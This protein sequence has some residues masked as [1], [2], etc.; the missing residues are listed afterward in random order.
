M[1]NVFFVL[2]QRCTLR[3]SVIMLTY[4]SLG[5]YNADASEVACTLTAP[6]VVSVLPG[7]RWWGGF[8]AQG[9]KMPYKNN[10]GFVFD[11][12]RDNF[13][14]QTAP[15]LVSSKG[16]YLWS[17]DPFAYSFTDQG[18]EIDG[19]VDLQ[20]VKAGGNLRDAYLSASEA[21]F[22]FTGETPDSLFFI[23]PQYNTWIELAYNQNQRDVMNYAAAA[24]AHGFPPGIFM[25][26]DNWQRYYGNFDFKSE[27]FPAP[28]EMCDSLHDLGFKVMTWICPFVSPDSPE[29]RTMWS[30]SYLLKNTSK[31]LPAIIPWWNGLSAAVDLTNP[32]AR[33][34]FKSKLE[35]SRQKYGIDGFK[36]DAGDIQYMLPSACS[37]AD[38]AATAHDYAYLWALTGS[39]FRFNELRSAWKNGGQP[40]VQRLGDKDYSWAALHQLVGDMISAGLLG[41]AYTCPDMIGGGM[42]GTFYTAEAKSKPFDQELMVRSCQ[43]HS[44]MPMMQFSVAPWRVLSAENSEICARYARLHA[45][46][47]P[48]IMK[49]ADHASKTGEPIVRHLEYEFPGQGFEDCTTQYMLGP[50]YMIAP[51]LER[52]DR[53]KV[54][55]PLG[56]WIDDRGTEYEGGQT[57]EIDVPLDRLPVF[58]RHSTL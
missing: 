3:L 41:Y 26:D 56:R 46:M 54:D 43:I 49:W 50:E 15:L 27:R 52:G 45:E 57:I 21:H 24:L 11:L 22:P 53:R 33:D 47:S 58:R 13:N 14:N 6:T 32:A 40:I 37:Y 12:R 9:L 51:M 44:M 5:A 36:F 19:A 29:Y 31:H 28:K 2:L 18:I 39:E 16:R 38:T 10:S 48:Y 8:V 34:Y 17:E 25:I 1:A 30:K 35:E 23:A 7:E 4:C 20:L 55:L 42:L